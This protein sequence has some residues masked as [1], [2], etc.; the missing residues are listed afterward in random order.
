MQRL[1][2]IWDEIVGLFVDDQL[3]AV[4]IL[5]WIA[6]VWL[7]VRRLDVAP[8]WGAPILF[9]GLAVIL[10]ESTTRAARR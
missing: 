7:T 1:R 9:F 2:T 4:A 5:I 6:F 8:A 10:V 3:Y